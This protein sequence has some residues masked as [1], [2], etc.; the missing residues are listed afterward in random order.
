MDLQHGVIRWNRL[1]R[2]IGMPPNASESACV[3]ELVGK[4]TPFLLLFA[5]D[6][7]DL[8]AE[9]AALFRKRVNMK[10]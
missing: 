2:E 3:V 4:S 9:L 6:H 10:T 8:V 5:A 1:K 7:T